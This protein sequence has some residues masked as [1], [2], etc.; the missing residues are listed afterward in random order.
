NA[1]FGPVWTIL[2]ILMGLAAGLVWNVGPERSDV[3]RALAIYV[4]QLGLNVL[5][6]LLFFGLR[7][8]IAALVDILMLLGAIIWC[9][10]VFGALRPAAG[11]LLLPYLAWVLFASVLNTAIVALN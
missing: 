9:M 4:L 10:Q 3:R 8:P 5:W 2:Y 7:S 6:T 1:V 11:R